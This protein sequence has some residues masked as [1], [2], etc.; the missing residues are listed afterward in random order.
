MRRRFFLASKRQLAYILWFKNRHHQKNTELSE[1]INPQDPTEER[2]S[3][4]L[5]E[6]L[7]HGSLFVITFLTTVLAGVQWLNKDPLELTN[8]TSGF[9]YGFLILLMLGSHEF[10]HYVAARRHRVRSTLP[11]FLP[12]PSVLFGLLFPFGTLGAVI[13]LRSSIPS[14]KVIFDIGVAGP[15]AGFLVSVAILI[16]GFMTLPP[17]EYLFTIHPEYEQLST[18][19]Q[20][21]LTFGGT[22]FY[23]ILGHIFA[24][25][26][27]FVP[28]MNEIYHYPFLCVGWFG[29]F[30]T[31]MNLIPI[32]QLDGGHI[33]YAMFGTAYHK[34]AQVSLVILVLLGT[35]GFLPLLNIPFSYGWTGWL[36]WALLLIFFMRALKMNRPLLA[37]ETP[38]DARRMAIGWCCFFIF[39][40]SFSLTPF[41][42]EL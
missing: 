39:I 23:S 16:V 1:Q 6:Y 4:S 20:A 11:F 9:A 36:F 42:L 22:I 3:I 14:R 34:I 12:F 17:K 7:I 31:A 25:S 27:A 35:A 29:L 18:I 30:V 8:F 37:D 13:K 15:I 32:A 41:T 24:P 10:G 19:P 28:P 40:G 33:A 26:G 21:G 5:R 2:F 38:L